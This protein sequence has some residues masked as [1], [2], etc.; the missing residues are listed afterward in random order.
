[1]NSRGTDK[2]KAER[3]RRLPSVHRLLNSSEVKSLAGSVP[4]AL[5]AQTARRVV[6]QARARLLSDEEQDSQCD[7]SELAAQVVREALRS[8]A[9]SLQR[10]INATGIVLHTGL[11]RARLA[12]AARDA[13]AAVASA[14]SLVE[15]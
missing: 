9:P 12:D 15:I 4:Q 3:M 1:M 11:G 2:Q 6:E 14:H 7:E 13:I 5:V 10:A 8:M